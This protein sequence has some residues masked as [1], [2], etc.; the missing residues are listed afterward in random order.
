MSPSDFSPK[1][2]RLL[3]FV[4][5]NESCFICRRGLRWEQRGLEWSAHH[6]KPRGRGGSSNPVI[7]SASNCLILCGS[8]TTGCHGDIESNRSRAEEQGRLI[9]TSATT[10]EYDP[11]EMPVQRTDGTWWLLTNSGGAHEI[12]PR[13]AR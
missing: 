13:E 5:D 10:P 3:F 7:G 11:D 12:E 4:R 9:P 1:L 8:G 2:V 6:R